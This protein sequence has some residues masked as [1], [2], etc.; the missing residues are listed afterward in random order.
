MDGLKRRYWPTVTVS[1]DRR[2]TYLFVVAAVVLLGEKC[3]V[4]AALPMDGITLVDNEFVVSREAES[5]LHTNL[6]FG[7]DESFDAELATATRRAFLATF[8]GERFVDPAPGSRLHAWLERRWLTET[9]FV[10]EDARALGVRGLDFA[11]AASIGATA[12]SNRLASL[13]Q[14]PPDK[15]VDVHVFSYA[16][17]VGDDHALRGLCWFFESAVQNRVFVETLGWGDDWVGYAMKPVTLLEELQSRDDI[18]DDDI[19]VFS[20][21]FDVL[22]NGGLDEIKTKFESMRSPLVFSA[23]CNCHPMFLHSNYSCS[24]FPDADVPYK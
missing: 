9:S 13:L 4:A 16:N 24:L 19:V 2:V 14:P 15:S 3:D 6:G 1:Y 21:A 20:D 7:E 5:A 18:D 10:R 8:D 17:R 12:E 11:R 22:F 23:D